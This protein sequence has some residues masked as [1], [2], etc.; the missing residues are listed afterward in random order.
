MFC[1]CLV[2]SV[3]PYHS[4]LPRCR[5]SNP[6]GYE[7]IYGFTRDSQHNHNTTPQITN[8]PDDKVHGANMGPT[9]VLSAPDGPMLAPWTL[10][11]GTLSIFYMIHCIQVCEVYCKHTIGHS[12][13][14]HN[15]MTHRDLLLAQTQPGVYNNDHKEQT[16]CCNKMSTFG[17]NNSLAPGT[18]E[19][20]F[21]QVI[22][23]PILVTDGWLI[24]CS[25][26]IVTGP[27]YL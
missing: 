9:W 19:W 24:S 10:L 27:H 4:G 17:I 8:N 1:C 21:R 18:I 5:W 23:K 22:F 14:I 7:W 11:S 13:Y 25:Q 6:K 16:G 15:S 2:W 26:V 3:Y 12:D 20:N